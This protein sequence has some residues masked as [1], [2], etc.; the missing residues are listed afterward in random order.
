VSA[1]FQ[2]DIKMVDEAEKALTTHGEDGEMSEREALAP[3]E[4][5][6]D[7]PRKLD[8][9]LSYMET[10]KGDALAGRVVK[11]LEDLTPIVKTYLDVGVEVKKATPGLEFWKWIILL[12]V[13]FLVFIAAIGALIY[14]RSTGNI[15]PAIALLIGGLVAYFFGYVRRQQ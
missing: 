11:M 1:D 15:D 12:V 10:D 2:K 3:E 6:Y 9:V 8:R 7:E 4:D 14:M 13:R 5:Y